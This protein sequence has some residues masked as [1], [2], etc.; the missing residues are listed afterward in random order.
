MVLAPDKLIP[1]AVLARVRPDFNARANWTGKLDWA[2]L[3]WTGLD[4]LGLA[5][6]L[7]GHV[8]S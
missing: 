3:D 7:P 4:W 2:G 6:Q 5:E 8:V 1:L